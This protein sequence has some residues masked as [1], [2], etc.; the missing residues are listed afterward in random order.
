MAMERKEGHLQ[1]LRWESV[2]YSEEVVLGEVEVV[3]STFTY[4]P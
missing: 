4:M 2:S 1:V 3:E